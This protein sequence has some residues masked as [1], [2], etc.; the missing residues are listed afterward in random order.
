MLRLASTAAPPCSDL[1]IG[2]V[3]IFTASRVVSSQNP[4]RSSENDTSK[5]GGRKSNPRCFGSVAVPLDTI[6][7]GVAAVTAMECEESL[8][9]V[10]AGDG[11]AEAILPKTSFL[12][13]L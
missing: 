5:R 2:M 10:V 11:V 12:N 4:F 3:A 13:P 8:G 6:D 9:G 1:S 7:D